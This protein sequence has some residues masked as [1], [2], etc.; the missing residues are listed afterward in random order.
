MLIAAGVTLASLRRRGEY[1]ALRALALGPA[2]LLVPIGVAAAAFAGLLVF[3]G[4]TVVAP[5]S[6][7]VDEVSVGHFGQAAG[8]RLYFGEVRWFRGRRHIYHLRRGSADEGFSEVTLFTLSED[9]RL[10]QRIDAARMVPVGG[11]VWRLSD[12]T[13]RN[14]SG[15]ETQVERFETRELTLDED[16]NAFRIIKARPEQLGFS[17]L[18]E[19][20]GLRQNVGLPAERWILTLH[21]KLAYPLGGLPGALLAC[22]LVLRPGRRSFMTSALAEGF[23]AIIVFW[24]VLVVFKAAA[25]AGMVAPALAAWAPVAFFALAALVAVRVLAR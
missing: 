19:Q 22:A 9:F 3:A 25:L 23:V 17:D 8:W 1:V 18:K 14:L 11:P 15:G 2:H 21:N 16:P 13:L 4:E 12:G 20:I 10:A 24:A 5:A 6:R 7:G